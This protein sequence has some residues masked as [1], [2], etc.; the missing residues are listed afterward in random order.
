[1][2]CKP[3]VAD[4]LDGWKRDTFCTDSD[5]IEALE[6]IKILFSEELGSQL[7]Y[8]IERV[9]YKEIYQKYPGVLMAHIYG[10]EH[11]LRF[12]VRIS[13]L[14]SNVELEEIYLNQIKIIIVSLIEYVQK[15]MNTFFATEYQPINQEE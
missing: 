2:P 6:M 11:L 8:R 14:L 13:W 12:F 3:S 15:N 1:M 4:I 10:A 7:L 9:Q 5:K